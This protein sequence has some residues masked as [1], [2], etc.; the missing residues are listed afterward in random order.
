MK[1]DSS[2]SREYNTKLVIPKK[3]LE[4][5][6]SSQLLSNVLESIQSARHVRADIKEL[7]QLAHKRKLEAH[8]KINSAL[9]Q[10]VESGRQ[11]EVK[12]REKN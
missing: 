6:V 2:K 12:S 7:V 11:Q 3:R 5:E 10:S 1:H 8:E 4:D 9:L